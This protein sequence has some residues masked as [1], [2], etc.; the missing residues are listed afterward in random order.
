MTAVAAERGP[1]ESRGAE[2]LSELEEVAP[3]L[4]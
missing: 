2:A 4:N 3:D 1:V